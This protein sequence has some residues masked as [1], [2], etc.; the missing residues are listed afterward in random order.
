MGHLES[1]LRREKEANEKLQKEKSAS[2][3]SRPTAASQ[4]FASLPQ[5][6][7]LTERLNKVAELETQLLNEKS[8]KERFKFFAQQ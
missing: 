8:E 3:T 4:A 1:E 6:L 7:N 5:D 2:L